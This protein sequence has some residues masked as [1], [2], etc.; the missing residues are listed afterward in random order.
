[1]INLVNVVETF[2]F[3]FFILVLITMLNK[4]SIYKNT[5]NFDFSS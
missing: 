3:N 1:M 4:F 2:D 5:V